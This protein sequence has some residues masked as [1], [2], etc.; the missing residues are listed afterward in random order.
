[1]TTMMPMPVPAPTP[2]SPSLRDLPLLA[3]QVLLSHLDARSAVFLACALPTPHV[4]HLAKERTAERLEQV[5]GTVRCALEPLAAA[6]TQSLLRVAR[7]VTAGHLY[8]FHFNYP[9][10]VTCFNFRHANLIFTYPR[11]NF[12]NVHV[13]SWDFFQVQKHVTCNV[14]VDTPS[15]PVPLAVF[16]LFLAQQEEDRQT[17]KE[18]YEPVW[19]GSDWLR[20]SCK[21]PPGSGLPRMWRVPLRLAMTMAVHR[22]NALFRQRHAW[23]AQTPSWDPKAR[24]LVSHETLRDSVQVTRFDPDW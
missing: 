18:F 24:R 17:T 2:Q 14:S 8:G 6:M 23:R 19:G 12:Y 10:P 5:A 3:M 13:D 9:L 15:G 20:E 21:P 7:E 4:T 16:S 22:F 11:A 1:M